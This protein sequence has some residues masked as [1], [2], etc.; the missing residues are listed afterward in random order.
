MRIGFTGFVLSPAGAQKLRQILAGD[1]SSPCAEALV[2]HAT[3]IG[4]KYAILEVPYT[5]QD[6]SSDYVNFYA[7]A[8]KDHLRYTRRVHLFAE[9]V[10]SWFEKSLAEQA[11]DSTIEAGYLGFVVVRPILQGPIGRTVLRFPDL[12][13]DLT[14]RVAARAASEVHLYGKKLTVTGAPFIQQDRRIGACAQAAI[15]MADRPMHIRHRRTA[16]YPIA[17]ITRLATTPTDAELSQE[18]PA[19]SAGLNP[20][21]I[22]RALKAM[23]HQPLHHYFRDA[24]GKPTKT[25]A[26]ETILRYLDSGLPVVLG[27]AS[28]G[29]DIA[30]AVAAVGYVE[31]T[32]GVARSGATY[33]AFVRALIVHDDQRGPY[34]LMPL[35]Q[36]DVDHIPRERLLM[37][38]E[39]ILIANEIV[40]HMFVPLP[41][42]VFLRAERADIVA[43]DFLK[44]QAA[45]GFGEKLATEAPDGKAKE[46][47]ADFYAR[48][49]DDKLVHRTYLTSAG[50]YRHHLA[51]STLS[52]PIKAEMMTRRLPHFVWV[53]ELMDPNT[54]QTSKNG[55]R[56]IVGHMVV[57]ATSSTDPSSDLL[58]AHVPHVVINR[59]INPPPDKRDDVEFEETAE[60]FP[61]ETP[62]CG[63]LR[64]VS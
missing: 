15:W 50:R 14:V 61:D 58:M 11:V 35:T 52:E 63:R 42:R 26:G 51:R 9:D 21:H 43:W 41:P 22:I 56:R 10:S 64:S 25:S 17:E 5:D 28:A 44:L 53:T 4:A 38:G 33:D 24:S 60:I 32:G 57:N 59:N 19:G 48:V 36:S 30:H 46:T 27:M 55:P 23:G 13:G 3:N 7:S 18:L 34:R 16:W 62:Y 29:D 40:S 8:F 54:V 1:R 12:D 49:R 20:M 6:Y 45:A 2:A 47:I 39:K 31:V 37:E